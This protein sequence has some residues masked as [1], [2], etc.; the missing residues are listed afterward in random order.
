[1]GYGAERALQVCSF[2][3]FEVLEFNRNPQKGLEALKREAEKAVREDGAECIL[4]RLRGLRGFCA[5]FA[6]DSRSTCTGRGS[7]GIKAS[8][9]Y[10]RSRAFH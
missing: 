4:L 8:G 10:G 3:A 2:H 5:G 7:T 9:G 6:K 1:M